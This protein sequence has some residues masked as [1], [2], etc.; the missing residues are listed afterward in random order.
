MKNVYPLSRSIS[1][2]T[3]VLNIRSQLQYRIF[4]RTVGA[5]ARERSGVGGAARATCQK[6]VL[7]ALI[8]GAF[9]ANMSGSKFQTFARFGFQRRP[10]RA[11][12]FAGPRAL[13]TRIYRP[14]GGGPSTRNPPDINFPRTS[15][16]RAPTPFLPLLR[17]RLRLASLAPNF[18]RRRRRPPSSIFLSS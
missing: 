8:S 7:L 10:G 13:A 5:G 11:R 18:F 1:V 12:V 15:N 17:L 9:A 14:P 6:N 16:E 4:R 2:L 3:R